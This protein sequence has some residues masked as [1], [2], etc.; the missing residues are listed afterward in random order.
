MGRERDPQDTTHFR[1]EAAVHKVVNK[2]CYF[3]A[4]V[5]TIRLLELFRDL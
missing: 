5:L 1:F 2:V 4:D 3:V